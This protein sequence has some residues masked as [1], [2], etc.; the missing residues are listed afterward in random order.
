MMV[1]ALKTMREHSKQAHKCISLLRNIVH[2]IREYT[3]KLETI[4]NDCFTEYLECAPTTATLSND[5]P[6][7][8][9]AMGDALTQVVVDGEVCLVKSG[10]GWSGRDGCAVDHA[11]LQVRRC[12][13]G[14]S[15]L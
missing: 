10:E 15:K 8:F 5:A 14:G 1:S 13:R 6:F 7:P 2:Q 3:Y 4:R 12:T 11:V 9:Q